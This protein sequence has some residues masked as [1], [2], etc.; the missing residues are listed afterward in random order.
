MRKC[1]NCGAEFERNFCPA[2]GT[3]AA[4]RKKCPS[5]GKECDESDKFCS[6]CGYRFESE[7]NTEV[8]QSETAFVQTNADGVQPY[9]AQSEISVAQATNS[10][11]KSENNTKRGKTSAIADKFTPVNIYKIL[12]Y[13]PAALFALFSVLI[14]IFY[15]ADVAVIPGEEDFPSI[16]LGN[17]YSMV[18]EL[19]ALKG[20][21]A[22]LI[23]F[24]VFGLILAASMVAQYFVPALKDKT[25]TVKNKNITLE[26]L[27]TG[28]AALFTFIYFVIGCAVCGT[29]AAEDGGFGIFAAGACPILIIVFSLLLLILIVGSPVARY[30]MPKKIEAVKIA[31]AD[32]E[33]NAKIAE[34]ERQDALHSSRLHTPH[35]PNLNPLQKLLVRKKQKK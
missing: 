3:E 25:F 31:V 11:L 33:K 1:T 28:A 10:D 7:S 24:A 17:V 35:L 18:S 32:E 30:I 16:G 5:C 22:A 6:N 29:I 15:A 19:S 13:V 14:F 9:D 8:K 34:A 20:S 2:C 12:K 27:L 21:M 26:L 4:H 23:V